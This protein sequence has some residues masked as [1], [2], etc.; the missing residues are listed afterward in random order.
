MVGVVVVVVGGVGVVDVAGSD[1]VAASVVGSCV[2]GGGLVVGSWVVSMV[3]KERSRGRILEPKAKWRMIFSTWKVCKNAT[4]S[5][6][7][8]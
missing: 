8:I 3:W 2:G 1:S 4:T 5:T 7:S 6:G